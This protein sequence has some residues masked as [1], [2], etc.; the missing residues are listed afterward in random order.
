MKWK[1]IATLKL[2]CGSIFFVMSN[3]PA[4]NAFGYYR[5]EVAKA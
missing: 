4:L 3:K 2:A 5:E 1:S